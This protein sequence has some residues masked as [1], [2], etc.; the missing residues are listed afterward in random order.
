MSCSH[1]YM[2]HLPYVSCYHSNLSLCP[3]YPCVLL[4]GIFLLYVLPP[5]LSLIYVPL[6]TMSCYHPYLS[7]C[8]AYC[9]ILLPSIPVLMSHLPLCPATTHICAIC[10]AYHSVLLLFRSVPY[11]PLTPLS[12]YHPYLFFMSHLP[13]CPATIHTCSLCPTYPSVLLPLICSLCPTYS[14]VLL[15][16][17]SVPY[18]PLH[19]PQGGRTVSRL[20]LCPATT[21]S[22]PLPPTEALCPT[23][24]RHCYPP[25]KRDTSRL[26]NFP[27]GSGENVPL[28]HAGCDGVL[29]EHLWPELSLVRGAIRGT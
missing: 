4:P 7:L 12:C 14:L 6:T 13:L 25:L 20:V 19:D 9:Y 27:W 17:I 28:C 15:P 10:P 23:H 26:Q 2:S 29:E 16:P 18:V 22:S 24:G 21:C 5:L 1:S 8:P 11:V 3:A